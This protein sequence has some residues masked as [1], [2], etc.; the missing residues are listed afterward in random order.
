MINYIFT[1]HRKVKN[2]LFPGLWIL[3]SCLAVSSPVS[4]LSQEVSQEGFLGRGIAV[5]ADS[6]MAGARRDALEDAK[7]KVVMTALCAMLSVDDLSKYFITLRNL[8]VSHPDIYLKWFKIINENSIYNTYHVNIH[9]FVQE[10]QLLNDLKTMGI[11]Y[12][13]VKKLKVLIM[14]A[15]KGIDDSDYEYWWNPVNDFSQPFNISQ[16][17]LGRYFEE[18]GTQVLIPSRISPQLYPDIDSQ[19][20]VIPPDSLVKIGLQ[21]GAD[22]VLFG[23]TELRLAEGR[24]L[25]SFVSVQCDMS[26]RLIDVRTG[27]TVVQAATFSLGLHVDKLSAT[28]DAVDKAG[29][30]LCEQLMNKVYFN[31][32]NMKE[33]QFELSFDKHADEG[34]VRGW[35]DSFL[36][37]FQDMEA[38]AVE[39]DTSRN[40]WIVNIRTQGEPADIV[41]TIFESGCEG[42]QTEVVSVNNNVIRFKIHVL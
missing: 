5:I 6:N 27:S 42:F 9:G 24:K 17:K 29:K 35:L 8:F 25:T 32:R 36:N 3:L 19:S 2:I 26:G 37:I 22:L 41:Q 13:E 15:Q 7:E 1:M 23:K 34:T 18:K 33:Y 31:I 28:L 4:V 14:V 40:L 21:A 11:T 12:S 16:E 39:N 38:M 10:E 30:Q 20:F